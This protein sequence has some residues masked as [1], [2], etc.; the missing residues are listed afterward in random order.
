MA[1]TSHQRH[2]LKRFLKELES[3][4][5]AHTEFVTVYVPQGYEMNKIVGHLAQEQGTAMNIKSAAT[6]KNVTDAL[7]RMIQHLRL[8]KHT[9]PNGLAVFSGNVLSREGKTDVRVWSIEPPIPLNIRIYKCDKNF[10]IE[11]LRDMLEVKEVYGLV[12]M[13]RR[14]AN[15]ALLKGKAIIHLL[16]THSQVPGKMKAGGQSAHR[17]EQNRELALKDH[18]KKVADYIKDQFLMRDNLKGIIVGGPG[19]TKYELVEGDFLTGDIQKKIIGIKD[20][21]YTGE[22]GIQELVDRSDD[23]LAK[24]E[25]VDE[26]K[27]MNEFLEK[28]GKDPDLVSYGETEVKKALEMG[29][30]QKLLLSETL[31]DQKID[32][33]ENIAKQY[34]TEV[35]LISTETREGVQL[36]DI[37]KF[38][39][40]LRYKIRM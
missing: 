25:L 39:A 16:K 4:K 23:I 17:F 26:K 19:P 13:D 10:E 21:S 20:L 34:S 30:V 38:G 40:I 22:F 3:Y 5:A 33:F 18:I 37:G 7:E 9:P 35:K 6:R 27:V 24:E 8:F 28:L 15:I 1:L 14:D 2:E 36:R 12:V 29:A 31:D 32:E 11:A